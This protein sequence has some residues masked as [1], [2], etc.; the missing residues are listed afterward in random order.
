MA[1]GYRITETGDFRITESSDSR[2]TENIFFGNAALSG[3]GTL[4]AVVV[5]FGGYRITETGD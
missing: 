2:V 1:G 3:T 4:S 5:T